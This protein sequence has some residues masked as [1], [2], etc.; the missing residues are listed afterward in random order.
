[1]QGKKQQKN[2]KVILLSKNELYLHRHNFMNT[3]PKPQLSDD[4]KYAHIHEGELFLIKKI[5]H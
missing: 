5:Q 2:A 1:M 4:I 3:L